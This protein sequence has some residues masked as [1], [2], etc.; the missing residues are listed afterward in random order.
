MVGVK[1]WD[2]FRKDL[3]ELGGWEELW[4]DLGL[5]EDA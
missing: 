2:H 4:T 5:V 3:E 1:R